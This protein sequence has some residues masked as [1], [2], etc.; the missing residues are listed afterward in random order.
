[1]T[2]KQEKKLIDR[3]CIEAHTEYGHD[4]HI[5]IPNVINFAIERYKEL[6]CKQD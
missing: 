6:K 2:S 3:I 4:E 1:M 5:S